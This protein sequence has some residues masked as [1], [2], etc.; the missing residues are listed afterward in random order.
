MRR[1]QAFEYDTKTSKLD[2]SICF[3]GLGIVVCV[4]ETH[5]WQ[6]SFINDSGPAVWHCFYCDDVDLSQKSIF[7][8]CSNVEIQ[9]HC[10]RLVMGSIYHAYVWDS[11]YVGFICRIS[12][13]HNRYHRTDSTDIHHKKWPTKEVTAGV[14]LVS[15]GLA[16]LTIGKD[17]SFAFGS[18]YCLAA[19]FLYAIHIIATNHFARRVDALILGIYQLGFASVFAAVGSFILETPVWPQTLIHWVAILGLALICSAYG[20]VMQ[21]IVQ[22]Y[23]TPES[24]GFLFSLEPIFAALF[25]FIFLNENMGL[26]GYIGAVIILCGVFIANSTFTKHK[27]IRLVAENNGIVEKA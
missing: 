19:A 22:K 10:W 12:S 6:H 23:T 8:R 2:F 14:I 18:F 5:G 17:F 3:D 25:A 15:F 26:Q 24:T 1:G 20:F 7:G 27:E 4:Y 9:C 11:A 13:E 21:P 16:L